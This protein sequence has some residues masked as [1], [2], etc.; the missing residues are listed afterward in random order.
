MSNEIKDNETVHSDRETDEGHDEPPTPVDHEQIS[1]EISGEDNHDTPLPIPTTDNPEIPLE[2]SMTDIT[3][4]EKEEDSTPIIVSSNDI[5]VTLPTTSDEDNN[6]NQTPVDTVEPKE[7]TIPADTVHSQSSN[8]P[9]DTP[10]LL[11][12]IADKSNKEASSTILNTVRSSIA[13][14]WEK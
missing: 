7:E 3:L 13:F 8:Q 12:T 2:T 6:N 10:P 4:E 9:D 5:P 1:A 11:R 14:C